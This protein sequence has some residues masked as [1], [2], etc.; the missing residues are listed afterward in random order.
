M[1]IGQG[2]GNFVQRFEYRAA[3]PVDL[4]DESD[5]RDRA[6]AA[7][8]EQLAGLRLDALGGVDHHDRGIDRRQ[9]AIGIFR[10]VFVARR[11]EQVEGYPVTFKGHDRAGHRDPAL[12]LDLHPV[13]AR[14][15]CRPARLDLTRQVDRPALQQQLLGQRGLARVRMRDDGKGAAI[16]HGARA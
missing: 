4:V 6:Q 9:R 8:L 15:P 10:E 11:V 13:R 2:I 16:G 1:P 7:D 5:D 3:F 12:L 14:P